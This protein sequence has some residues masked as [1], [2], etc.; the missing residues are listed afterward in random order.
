MRN[1]NQMIYI[2]VPMIVSYGIFLGI[3]LASQRKKTEMIYK[4]ESFQLLVK[5]NGI[6]KKGLACFSFLLIFGPLPLIYLSTLFNSIFIDQ[7]LIIMTVF[8]I[9]G[10]VSFI[11]YYLNLKIVTEIYLKDRQSAK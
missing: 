10:A 4:N 6:A 2:I 11:L 5:R 7:L 1:S 3:F 9:L 8:V